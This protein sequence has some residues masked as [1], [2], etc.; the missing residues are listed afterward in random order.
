MYFVL[1]QA[2]P[3]VL[4]HSFWHRVRALL[5]NNEV[6][7]TLL[8][9]IPARKQVTSL[10]SQCSFMTD[11]SFCSDWVG[12]TTRSH[13]DGREKIILW[14]KNFK[15]QFCNRAPTLCIPE[16]EKTLGIKASYLLFV[17]ANY[18]GLAM[19]VWAKLLI[20]EIFRYIYCGA[21]NTILQFERT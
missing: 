20:L 21:V 14:T 19:S 18:S 3:S 8:V 12:L 16:T 6:F 4:K 7:G 1:L 11:N 13:G 5:R 10:P 9:Y 2:M 15:G 17:I